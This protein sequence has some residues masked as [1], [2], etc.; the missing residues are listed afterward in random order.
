MK[1]IL[2]ILFLLQS[3]F[4]EETYDPSADA[5]NDIKNAITLAKKNNKHVFVKVGG[6]WCGWCKLYAR[7]TESDEE[8]AQKISERNKARKNK[9]YKA[10]D[11]I[12]KE[13]LDKGV[14]IED[15]DDKTLW[16]FK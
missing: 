4:S 3:V 14:L 11:K 2:L 8:I 15:K 10:A 1:S 7:F 16:K 5:L 13:L 12:R 6:N 9:D